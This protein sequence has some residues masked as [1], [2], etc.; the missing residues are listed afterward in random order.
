MC[1][2]AHLVNKKKT[3]YSIK[4]MLQQLVVSNFAK[5]RVNVRWELSLNVIIPFYIIVVLRLRNVPKKYLEYTEM[6]RHKQP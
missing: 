2:S 3:D 1:C 6:G 4:I 5:D